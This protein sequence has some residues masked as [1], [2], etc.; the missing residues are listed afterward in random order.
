VEDAGAGVQER[1]HQMA[2]EL[3]RHLA[4]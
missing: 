2:D 4:S 3:A 1:Y